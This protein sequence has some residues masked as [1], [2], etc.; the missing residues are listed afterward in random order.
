MCAEDYV[1]GKPAPDCFLMAARRLNVD[2][3][4]CLVLEDAVLGIQAARAAGMSC[5][6]VNEHAEFGHEVVKVNDI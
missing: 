1:N 3:A 4:E 2:P 6:R 5:L